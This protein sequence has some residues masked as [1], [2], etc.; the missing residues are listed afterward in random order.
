VVLEGQFCICRDI[1]CSIDELQIADEAVVD[2]AEAGV[3]DGR[4]CKLDT[5]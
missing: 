4:C 1:V 2:I 3:V 5:I